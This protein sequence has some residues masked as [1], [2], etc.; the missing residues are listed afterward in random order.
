MIQQNPLTN[1]IK[2]IPERP[3]WLCK[4]PRA[5]VFNTETKRF[6]CFVCNPLNGRMR[7]VSNE[8]IM[9]NLRNAK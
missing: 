3:S 2:I 9:E 4:H 5:V 1:L 7:I 8:F 6:I